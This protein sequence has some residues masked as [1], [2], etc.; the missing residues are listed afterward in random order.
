MYFLN[1]E[2]EYIGIK[3]LC[4][5]KFILYFFIGF[6]QYCNMIIFL[7]LETLE[8][9]S[10]LSEASRMFRI[11]LQKRINLYKIWRVYRVNV[12]RLLAY[13]VLFRNRIFRELVR[14]FMELF[15]ELDGLNEEDEEF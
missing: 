13:V 11:V 9:E 7:K 4:I 3:C 10:T 15:L 2:I 14:E 8:F 1:V 12:F 6:C 5:Y